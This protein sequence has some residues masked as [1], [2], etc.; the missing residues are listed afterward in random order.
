M[1]HGAMIDTDGEFHTDDKGVRVTEDGAAQHGAT[2]GG[3]VQAV[4]DH[5]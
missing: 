4:E 5:L 3:L 1:L 2:V